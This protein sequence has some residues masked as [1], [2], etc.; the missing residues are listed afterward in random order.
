VAS[1]SGD[2]N[3]VVLTDLATGSKTSVSAHV[4]AH[5]QVLSVGLTGNYLIWTTS[6]WAEP[7]TGDTPCSVA[8]AI[9]WT[10]WAR[11]LETG[12]DAQ[13]A[14]GKNTDTESC[15][16][17]F[18]GIAS[19]GD[20]V[21]YAVE[22]HGRASKEATTLVIRS[23]VTGEI[24]R[25]VDTDLY[26]EDLAISGEDVAFIDG[27]LSTDPYADIE[28]PRL[29]VSLA[30][31]PAVS[32]IAKNQYVDTLSFANGRLAWLAYPGDSEQIWTADVDDLRP[33]ALTGEDNWR[34]S[35]PDS[36]GDY[37]T[38]VEG[39]GGAN[40]GTQIDIWSR[41]DS[42]I[43]SVVPFAYGVDP[44][45]G[46]VLNAWTSNGWLLWDGWI[47]NDVSG[48]VSDVL[49]GCLLSDAGIS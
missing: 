25:T 7:H 22:D 17:Y 28:S 30:D 34:Y 20:L 15:A 33:L 32:W 4:R 21:A 40:F 16:A 3:D 45:Q 29:G 6:S 14:T 5:Q 36:S 1:V 42:A 10:V 47:Y 43:H 8:G 39:S 49:Q 48:D 24:V 19:D 18:A 27:H 23:L 38:W 31:S 46:E 13:I 37:V 2:G 41:E 9:S 35:D 26:I 11:D 12:T 44:G